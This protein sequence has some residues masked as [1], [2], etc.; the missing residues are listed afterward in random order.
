MLFVM[1]GYCIGYFIKFCEIWNLEIFI[2]V[3]VVVVGLGGVFVGGQ[4]VQ[5]CVVG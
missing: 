3:Q 5:F 1:C 4:E 2:I